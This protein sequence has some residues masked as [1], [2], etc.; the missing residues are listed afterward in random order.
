MQQV[1]CLH[2]L[3]CFPVSFTQN[4]VYYTL[5]A[6][7]V[8]PMSK[9]THRCA[10][11]TEEPRAEQT[12][13][14]AKS[15]SRGWVL[16]AS[17]K[18]PTTF[19]CR[20]AM[21]PRKGIYYEFDWEAHRSSALA[22]PIEDQVSGKHWKVATQVLSRRQKRPAQTKRRRLGRTLEK[23]IH[24]QTESDAGSEFHDPVQSDDEDNENDIPSTIDDADSE[25]D[26]Q[27][28]KTDDP[29]KTPSRKRKRATITSTS[30]PR[31]P[32]TTKLAAP[33]P[34][35]KAALRARAR[36]R[37]RAPAVRLP[38]PD[39]QTQEHYQ[40]LENLPEDPWL[41]AM[42]VLHVAARPNNLPC[43]EE[44]FNRVLRTV[45]ELLEEGSGGCVCEF[46]SSLPVCVMIFLIHI[47]WPLRRAVDISGVPG[48]GKTAT[49][50]AVVRELKRMAETGVRLF[51]AHHSTVLSIES[52][53]N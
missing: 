46:L 35:S 24:S 49:V 7:A 11:S 34:H 28:V 6:Q 21:E 38:P 50:H 1:H 43:R 2:P 25:T 22:R 26:I 12:T 23:D 31:R 36:S 19:Y 8:L 16:P 29:P 51:L 42:H 5:D 44:E 18:D 15:R 48:T 27:S 14:Q 30:T 3:S 41:R 33:T 17:E 37:K 13:P 9:I 39:F 20:L 4:E 52:A 53:G 47:F 32:H 10:V 40:Q 45:E